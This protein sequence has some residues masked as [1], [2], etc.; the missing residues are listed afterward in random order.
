MATLPNQR[1]LVVATFGLALLAAVIG[2]ASC[3][4]VPMGGSQALYV[5]DF[6]D[7]RKLVGFADDVFFAQVVEDLGASQARG[8]PETQ[9][10]V[11][12]LETLKGSLSGEV[13][14]NQ[15]AEFH[16][17][18]S[19]AELMG[20]PALLGRGNSYFLI[21][22]ASQNTSWHTVASPYGRLLIRG[23]LKDAPVEEALNSRHANDL[24][25][26]FTKAVENETPF[27]P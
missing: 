15:S 3:T 2:L 18:R 12:V 13:T 25:E 7:D 27:A 20:E 19:Q 14:V 6:S 23:V 9:F 21:T 8:L 22:R 4:N 5:T 17:G 24:R 26:R 16:G 10:R 1:L 11:K